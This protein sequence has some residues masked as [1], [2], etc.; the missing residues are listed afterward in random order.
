MFDSGRDPGLRLFV[1]GPK[2]GESRPRSTG[3]GSQRKEPEQT[4]VATD[5]TWKEWDS[6]VP[7]N[8]LKERP[9]RG[10]SGSSRTLRRK[11]QNVENGYG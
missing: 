1:F 8:V 11:F 3:V 9:R 5:S 2:L 10:F 6:F 7:R 4:G